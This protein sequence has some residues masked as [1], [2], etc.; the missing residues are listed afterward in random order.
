MGLGKDSK[1]KYFRNCSLFASDIKGSQI[2]N[3]IKKWKEIFNLGVKLS[4]GDGK[5]IKFWLFAWI[6][7]KPLYAIHPSS[8]L[9]VVHHHAMV[10]EV[11]ATWACSVGFLR[12]LSPEGQ[13]DFD[14]FL[15]SLDEVY[16]SSAQD[17]FN[18]GWNPQENFR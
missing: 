6:A 8:F 2:W 13:S 1:A 12:W 11:F 3:G 16:L 18:W 14:S 7:D 15:A 4:I 17:S 9:I 5:D 10:S